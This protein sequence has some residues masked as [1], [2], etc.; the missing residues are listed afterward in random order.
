[1]LCVILDSKVLIIKFN[2]YCVFYFFFIGDYWKKSI[3]EWINSKNLKYMFKL[4]IR[5]IELFFELFGKIGNIKK[6]VDNLIFDS[7]LDNIE[8]LNIVKFFYIRSI[9]SVLYFKGKFYKLSC[10]FENNIVV[11]LYVYCICVVGKGGF[12]NYIYVL[13]KMLV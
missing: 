13:L 4:I 3:L 8:C 6:R 10:V 11:V 9:C 2:Y 12:C 1:M 5:E 7:F